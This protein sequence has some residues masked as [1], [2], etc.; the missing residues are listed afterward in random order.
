MIPKTSCFFG[1]MILIGCF[2]PNKSEIRNRIVGK[3]CNDTHTLILTDSQTYFN[4]KRLK[5][6]VANT[7]YQ[8]SCSGRYEI[9]M[10]EEHWVIR[11][12]KDNHPN[13]LSNCQ[14]EFTLWTEKEGFLIGENEVTMRDLF[15]NTPMKRCE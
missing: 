3:Y 11:F 10:K 5:G 9:E 8:E 6:I 7:P 15:D 1:L 13:A 14:Q 2:S 4:T 12:E